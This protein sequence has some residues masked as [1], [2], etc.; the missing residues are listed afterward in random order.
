ME[1]ER[2]D[3]EYHQFLILETMHPITICEMNYEGKYISFLEQILYL[4]DDEK[5]VWSFSVINIKY[6]L[7]FIVLKNEI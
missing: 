7:G 4:N 3:Q 2:E 1:R 6:L 5:L